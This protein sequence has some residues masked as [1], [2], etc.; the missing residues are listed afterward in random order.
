M[1]SVDFSENCGLISPFG[2]WAIWSYILR[3]TWRNF[4]KCFFFVHQTYLLV[5]KR[6]NE[7]LLIG[8]HM[9]LRPW[10]PK[11]LITGSEADFVLSVHLCWELTD[12]SAESRSLQSTV[13]TNCY[14]FHSRV[15]IG[16]V[17]EV[18]VGFKF[19]FCS[20]PSI[21]PG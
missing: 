5:R 9:T 21:F 20:K 1:F 14:V 17:E 12:V 7:T 16:L 11:S 6:F 15:G 3:W 10:T 18:A 19:Y 13:K 2:N 4:M 8:K